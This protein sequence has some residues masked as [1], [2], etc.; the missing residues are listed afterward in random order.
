MC[1]SIPLSLNTTARLL[2]RAELLCLARARSSSAYLLCSRPLRVSRYPRAQERLVV[3]C[4]ASP[5]SGP[6]MRAESCSLLGGDRVRDRRYSFAFLLPFWVLS[7]VSLAASI[8]LCA[9][10]RRRACC[11]LLWV[12]FV[13]S[14]RSRAAAMLITLTETALWGF[15]LFSFDLRLGFV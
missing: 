4:L 2:G 9:V 11:R 7:L 14:R 3:H 15:L 13:R 10:Q 8:A 1:I 6:F 12:T 5:R